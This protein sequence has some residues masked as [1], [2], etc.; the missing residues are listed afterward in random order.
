MK[1]KSLDIYGFKSFADRV[2]VEFNEG[3]T[4]IVGPNGSGK[5]NV[6]D[7]IRWV[8]GEQSA[9]SLRGGH[10]QDIIFSGTQ[11][12][13]PLGFAEVSLNFDNTDRI[14]P[15]QYSEISVTRRL[16]RSGESEYYINRTSCRLKDILELFMDTGIGK[17]GYSIIGQ[18]RIDE[19]LS[20]KGEER[21]KVFEEAAGIV[22]YKTR[23]TESERKLSKTRDN[24]IRVEDIL[25]EIENQIGPL[26]RQSFVAKEYLQIKEQLKRFEINEF[27]LKYQ[28]YKT[29]I[30]GLSDSTSTLEQDIDK[31]KS[32]VAGLEE[33]QINL[34][35]KLEEAYARAKEL[36]E[37]RIAQ[38]QTGEEARTQMAVVRERMEAARRDIERLKSELAQVEEQIGHRREEKEILAGQISERQAAIEKLTEEMDEI[39]A[40]GRRIQDRLDGA[41]KQSTDHQQAMMETRESIAQADNVITDF[42]ATQRNLTEQITVTENTVA[43]YRQRAH[44]LA[45]RRNALSPE[46]D[47]IVAKLKEHLAHREELQEKYAAGRDELEAITEKAQEVRQGLEG[48]IQ[49]LALLEDMKRN[50]E[51]YFHSVKKLLDAGEKGQIQGLHGTVGDLLSVPKQYETPI[52]VALGSAQQFVVA[53]DEEAAKAA[54]SY[55]KQNKAGRATF[56]PLT[57]IKPRTLDKREEEALGMNGCMG[58][59]SELVKSAPA[60]DGVLTY[61]LGRVVIVD[62]MDTAIAMGRRFSHGFKIVTMDGQ[63]FH[64][65][66][67][68]TG[69][70][71]DRRSSGLLGRDRQIKELQG[72]IARQT[73]EYQ[74]LTEQQKALRTEI[75]DL[76]EGIKAAESAHKEMDVRRAEINKQIE[77]LAEQIKTNEDDAEKASADLSHIRITIE[78]A[79]KAVAEQ[80]ETRGKLQQRLADMQQEAQSGES[81]RE[82]ILREQQAVEVSLAELRERYAVLDR[83]QAADEQRMRNLMEWLSEGEQR[84]QDARDQIAAQEAS[85]TE[86]E[87][88]I[89]RLTQK[90]TD[91]QAEQEGSLEKIRLAETETQK[92]QHEL[93]EI[94]G[95]IRTVR[96]AMEELIEKRHGHEVKLSRLEA[97]LENLQQNIWE[98]YELSYANALEY[99]DETLDPSE[100]TQETK[101]LKKRLSDL[102]E[103]NV[104]AIEEYKKVKE[105]YEYLTEQRDDLIRAKEDLTELIQDLTQTMERRFVEEF[106]VINEH[107][108]KVFFEL[109][110]GGKAQLILEDASDALEC[111]IEI[112][113]QPPGKKL[114]RLSL[115]SGGERALTAI[116]ILFAILRH[117]PTPFCVLDE[118]ETA[119]D[120]HNVERYAQFLRDF[121]HQ[122]QF[123]VITHRKGTMNSSHVLYGIAME[124][125]GVSKMVS[126][127]L[128]D[129]P[130]AV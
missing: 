53:E 20:M 112:V 119:L 16:F 3:I 75:A 37:E 90:V 28:D 94:E 85:G 110:G 70:S 126:V 95:R 29:Q 66:G 45:E 96:D 123:V 86:G 71:A 121:S 1:L 58:L 88:E 73:G 97:D 103:V 34:K 61:L 17:E 87:G 78:T 67:S 55:L 81:G 12:R 113:A 72:Q 63:V 107:F 114:Q 19:L 41:Q 108:T 128:E 5:S 120:D 44:G 68:I 122:T 46:L 50:R 56:L 100:I 105:R 124:E 69:G 49:K 48:H 10:M 64:P 79:Q 60:Y 36:N 127:S 59:G 92:V 40:Q 35:K 14:L 111:G 74:D 39:A 9:K 57:S 22:K 7:A 18:G 77:A 117:K 33:M 47:E 8:L 30:S 27:I 80:E 24:I 52:E 26:E 130:Q 32:D 109:F 51:G 101:T 104:N 62:T 25:G 23:R 43:E 42:K 15:I 98:E 13:K 84:I 115:L 99:R 38:A 31:H 82:E 83:E 118:I 102:G 76:E 91:V 4:A 6:A 116:A 54:V 106:A 89:A 21:R 65:G 11:I 2:H 125:R 129:I 93:D